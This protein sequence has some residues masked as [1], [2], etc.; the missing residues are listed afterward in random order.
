MLSNTIMLIGAL[1]GGA[2]GLQGLKGQDYIWHRPDILPTGK[3]NFFTSQVNEANALL[4]NS[5][6]THAEPGAFGKIQMFNDI[7]YRIPPSGD[8]T[9][10]RTQD[11]ILKRDV[12]YLL[13]Y[14]INMSFQ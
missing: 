14:W 7:T 9:G 10:I 11:P 2:I 1:L 8:P 12:L 4:F 5:Y 6:K 13:S 3:V